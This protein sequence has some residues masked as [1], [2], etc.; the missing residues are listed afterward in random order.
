MKLPASVTEARAM[1]AMNFP[2]VATIL[3]SKLAVEMDNP[4]V[5]TLA[6]TMEKLIINRKFFEEELP[7]V[8]LRASA[9][10]HEVL[11][12]VLMHPFR[13]KRYGE[14]GIGTPPEKF[15]P[16]RYNIAAD[17]VIN[18]WLAEMGLP[19]GDGWLRSKEVMATDGVEDIYFRL[20]PPPPDNP[21]PPPSGGEGDPQSGDGKGGG[22]PYA[23]RPE[24]ETWTLKPSASSRR[25]AEERIHVPAD[26]H[27][28][29]GGAQDMHL[30][31]DEAPSGAEEREWKSSV[32]GAAMAA[33]AM[34]KLPEFIARAVDALV[35]PPKK[36][37]REVLREFIV[38]QTGQDT[39]DPSRFNQHKSRT[40]GVVL[41]RRKAEALDEAVIIV[42]TS[43]SI[44]PDELSMMMA[45]TKDVFQQCSVRQLHVLMV[46]AVVHSHE[47]IDDLEDLDAV[48]PRGGGG[49][50]MEEGFRWCEQNYVYPAVCI[51]LTD[52]YTSF[53]TPPDFPVVWVLTEELSE[54]RKPPYGDVVCIQP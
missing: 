32:K 23:P 20:D 47:T 24:A 52:G 18:A 9:I 7:T 48:K 41:N 33:R 40:L 45:A 30:P 50:D 26:K 16:V 4:A 3:Y 5:P 31:A 27:G 13:M 42:D 21:K 17:L 43:G 44:T 38:K 51:V 49:T 1:V 19:L 8:A 12:A 11:H 36:D 54:S 35:A 37:W 34:G 28:Q 39:R 25:G 53:T 29:Q 46:S 14:V 22:S 6:V 15:D 2:F 10:T